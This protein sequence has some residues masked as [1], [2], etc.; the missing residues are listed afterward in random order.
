[1]DD[2]IKAAVSSEMKAT[3]IRYETH[4]DGARIWEAKENQLRAWIAA[5]EA[6]GHKIVPVEPTEAMVDAGLP[7]IPLIGDADRHNVADV[8]E[9]M[10]TAYGQKGSLAGHYLSDRVY[11]GTR[12]ATEKDAKP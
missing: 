4:P 11:D 8:W 3:G 7:H 12:P 1:M 5:I 2:L 6:S 10:L 9:A